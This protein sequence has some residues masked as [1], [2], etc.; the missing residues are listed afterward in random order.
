MDGRSTLLRLV[1]KAIVH[2]RL[3]LLMVRTAWRFRSADWYRRPPFLPL[4]P[5]EY[6][7]WRWQTAWGDADGATDAAALERYLRWARWMTRVKQR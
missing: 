2:P 3:G 4:P 5:T 7:A 6:V 1:G